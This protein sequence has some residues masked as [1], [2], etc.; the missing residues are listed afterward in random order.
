MEKATAD[1]AACRRRP[2]AKYVSEK[3]VRNSSS[4]AF[5]NK[6]CTKNLDIRS[7]HTDIVKPMVNDFDSSIKVSVE[8]R[9]LLRFISRG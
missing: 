4:L 8:S 5:I 9:L 2:M 6:C 7:T 3:T 1:T